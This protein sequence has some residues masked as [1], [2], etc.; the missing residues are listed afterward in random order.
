MK[1]KQST[2][3]TMFTKNIFKSVPTKPTFVSCKY[4]K[5][6]IGLHTSFKVDPAN[7]YAVIQVSQQLVGKQWTWV[8]LTLA[9]EIFL[10]SAFFAWCYLVRNHR[11]VTLTSACDHYHS[12]YRLSKWSRESRL[13]IKRKVFGKLS[14]R[15]IGTRNLYFIKYK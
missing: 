4:V 13:L 10:M 6:I 7:H 5:Q 2:Y 14:Y 11:P 12:S 15:S 3:L 1:W 8:I 9:Y